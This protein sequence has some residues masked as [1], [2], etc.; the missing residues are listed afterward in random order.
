MVITGFKSFN[1]NSHHQAEQLATS[2]CQELA[3][4][5][6]RDYFLNT[7]PEAIEN[8]LKNTDVFFISLIFD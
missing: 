6:F 5:V 1:A 2:S 7:E 4:E 3:V 8:A